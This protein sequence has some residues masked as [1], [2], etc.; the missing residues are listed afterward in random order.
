MPVLVV[1]PLT[2][3]Q[4]ALLDL[5]RPGWDATSESVLSHGRRMAKTASALV[6]AVTAVVLLDV[7]YALG[8]GA[9]AMA[10]TIVVAL[11]SPLWSIAAQSA[12]HHGP[13]TLMLTASIWLLLRDRRPATLCAAGCTMAIA[14][15]IRVPMLLFVL[16]LLA[17]ALGRRPD[18][19]RWI[20]PPLALGA[21]SLIAYN[22]SVFGTPVGGQREL[23]VV[24]LP[25]HAVAGSWASPLAGAAGTLFSPGRGLFVYCPWVLVTLLVLPLARARVARAS[26]VVALTLALVGH[27][28]LFASYSAWWAGWCFGPRY[29]TEAIPV[30]GI[31]YAFALEA[32]RTY[33]WVK[34]PLYAA[35]VLAVGIHAFAAAYY[36]SS[37]NATPVSVDLRHERLWDWQDTEI[38]RGLREGPHPPEFPFGRG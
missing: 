38:I 11:G 17:W 5:R 27:L 31:L 15:A 23:E 37:W 14:V 26:I 12:W 18:D 9:V 30:L 36:P 19:A 21:A 16:P 24:R 29:W 33:A 25:I 13:A 28:V 7:L 35:G 10:A 3:A 34:A 32:G 6:V 2:W 22:L 4:V 1:L 8:L 20:V